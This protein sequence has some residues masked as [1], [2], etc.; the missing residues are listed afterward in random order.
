MYFDGQGLAGDRGH[1]AQ[2]AG[3][4]RHVSLHVEHV[5]VGL[6]REPSRV[7]GDTLADE[8]DPLFGAGGLP[9]EVDEPRFLEAALGH[10]E[11]KS[12][13]FVAALGGSE[14][15]DLEAM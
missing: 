10:G 1:H 8:S 6:E 15:G 7:E 14:D 13:T 9:G 11:I 5:V 4:A 3:G 2:D 12:H